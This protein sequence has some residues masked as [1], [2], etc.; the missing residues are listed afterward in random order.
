M[1]YKI[2]CLALAVAFRP[3]GSEVAVCA[4]NCTIHFYD[5]LSSQQTGLIEAK[6]DLGRFRRE[7]DM[8]SAKTASKGR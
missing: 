3:D 1:R 4:L 7:T 6:S 8:V 5:P 2:L